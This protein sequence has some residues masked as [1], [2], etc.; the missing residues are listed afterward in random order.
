M[1]ISICE[2]QGYPGATQLRV[3]EEDVVTGG[4]MVRNEVVVREELMVREEEVVRG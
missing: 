4:E 1:K 3:R 2:G